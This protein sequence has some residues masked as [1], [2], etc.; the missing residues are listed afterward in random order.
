MAAG[1]GWGWG[2]SPA[3]KGRVAVHRAVGLSETLGGNRVLHRDTHYR[4]GAGSRWWDCCLGLG[5]VLLLMALLRV[6]VCYE[7]SLLQ[8][9][10]GGV[11]G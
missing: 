7:G 5:T 9:G 6:V 2:G 4:K 11:R 3:I 8:G 10:W 1:A